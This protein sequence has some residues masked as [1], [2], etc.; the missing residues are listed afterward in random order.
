MW[1][2]GH[3]LFWVHHPFEMAVRTFG[4]NVRHGAALPKTKSEE[5]Q[6]NDKVFAQILQYYVK[7]PFMP[8]VV[9]ICGNII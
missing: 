1:T 7:D 8:M 6:Q 5:T 3:I 4:V 2:R 9:P